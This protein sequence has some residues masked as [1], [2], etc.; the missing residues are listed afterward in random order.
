VEPGFFDVLP[1]L[2]W[3]AH[4][5][6]SW[7]LAA[8]A[9]VHR[10]MSRDRGMTLHILGLTWWVSLIMEVAA[11]YSLTCFFVFP[12]G[13]GGQSSLRQILTHFHVPR[14]ALAL[15]MVPLVLSCRR[16][17]PPASKRAAA[18]LALATAHVSLL[19]HLVLWVLSTP[20][21]AMPSLAAYLR[22]LQ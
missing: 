4:T 14:I 21:G 15:V 8:M 7:I 3:N 22:L 19:L 1:Y 5:A 20:F 11:I 9:L 12:S 6:L 13:C 18:I 2:L 17:L 16:A 10:L